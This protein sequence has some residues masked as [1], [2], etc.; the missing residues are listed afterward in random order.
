[1][2]K[3]HKFLT[4]LLIVILCVCMVT[5]LIACDKED[6]TTGEV[7]DTS[8]FIANGNFEVTTSD[9][10]P[11]IPGS[12]TGSAGSTTSGNSTDLDEDSLVAGVID[13]EKSAYDKNKKLWNRLPNPGAVATT[14]SNILMIYNKKDNSY[15]YTSS[16]FSLSA[17]K[18]FQISVSVKTDKLTDNSYGAYIKIAGDAFTEFE[19]IKTGGSWQTYTTMIKTSNLSSNSISVVLSNGKD[20][21]KDGKLSNG[22]AF[23]DNVVVTEVKDDNGGK[24]AEEKYNDFAAAAEN[25]EQQ[26]V[27]D[28]TNG[29]TSFI[30]ISGSEN[31]FTARKW[32]GVSSSGDDGETAPTGSDYLERGVIDTST[33]GI[34]TVAEGIS[35]KG[36]DSKFL[37]LNNK[38]ATAYGYRS[39][40]RFKIVAN[41][42]YKLSVWVLTKDI[43]SNG[44]YLML[45]TSTDKNEQVKTIDNITTNGEWSQ[46]SFYIKGDQKRNKEI[47]LQVGLGKGGKNDSINNV[48]GIAF[49]DEITLETIEETD[50]NN[51]SADNKA[52]LESKLG[53]G[54]NIINDSDIYAGDN[55]KQ[56]T[57][58]KNDG[59]LDANRG[60][61]TINN[62]VIKIE[63]TNPSITKYNYKQTL[64]IAANNHYRLSF[65]VKTEN[66]DS[67]RGIEIIIYK[68][69]NE[70]KDTELTKISDFNS[71]DIEEDLLDS[72]GYIE[73][74]FLIQGD[75]KKLS[76]IYFEVVMGTGSNLTPNS[77]VKGAV[78]LTE[79]EMYKVNYSDYNSESSS[80][81]VKKHS[82]KSESL[83]ITNAE[84][85][86]IDISATKTQYEDEFD[87]E[88]FLNGNTEKT[89]FGLPS[90]WTTSS[91]DMLK[92]IYAGVYD[93][94]NSV[95]KQ[96]LALDRD[97]IA[98]WGDEPVAKDNTNLLVISSNKKTGQQIDAPWGFTS[99]SVSLSKGKYYEL[100]VWAYLY[101]GAD[102]TINLQ[103][104]NKTN[105]E[106]FEI[107]ATDTGWHEYTFYINAGFDN[108][109]IY[110]ELKLGGNAEVKTDGTVFFDR[111]TFT[112]IDSDR[113]DFYV[114]E[115]IETS[116]KYKKAVT[117]STTTFDNSTSNSDNEALDT[118]DGWTGSHADTDAPNGKGKS[119]AGVYNRDHGSREWFGGEYEDG[120]EKAAISSEDL[121]NIMDTAPQL[122]IATYE[123]TIEGAS[124]NNVL[125]INNNAASEYTYTTTLADNSLTANKY[126][127]IS[128]FVLTYDVD[129]S[130]TAKIA[131]K[132]HNSTFE[133]SNN[134]S[135]GINVNTAGKWRRYSFFISTE[136]NAD[137]DSVQLS[138]SLGASGEE[139]YVSGYLFIDNVSISEITED[140]FN[141]QV[142]ADK[143]PET[144]EAESGF[145]FDKAFSSQKH[146]IVFTADDLNKEPEEEKEKEV[147]PLLWLYITSG[148]IGGLIVIVVIIFL[149]KKF[150]VFAR[151]SKKDNFNEKGS[152][153]YNRNRVEANKANAQKRDINQKHQD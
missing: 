89:V 17:N 53:T 128:V 110:L 96:L 108:S 61:L 87:E 152:E 18:I 33:S 24:T 126:Y 70:G 98:E 11:K 28:L 132:L 124:N 119:I 113:Y 59:I 77:L 136:D 121:I 43:E 20:G 32:T 140:R 57:Y 13:T 23:F 111:P 38:Q 73:L 56:G 93:V 142:P 68:K 26:A 37:M 7:K 149:L 145:E 48:K 40:N 91:K 127:E 116:P 9:T 134:E 21:K 31:P 84:F 66:I 86:Q 36:K 146:R 55:Y 120:K 6:E 141:E 105:I 78:Y 135:R 104:S 153:T 71:K 112:E 44:A 82:L 102:A 99:P 150:N 64:E 144:N 42:Y 92:D 100:S 22:Y 115:I 131:L 118:P 63:N 85:N 151:F 58:D 90:N 81:Y 10:F 27:N 1:M 41:K 46:I 133:F 65:K 69:N 8:E 3:K 75:L 125:V 51:A 74:A 45:K 34:P 101:K 97:L 50:Y 148:I 94:T 122:N 79:F 49:F 143:F 117:F 130:K 60:K 129:S 30:N 29:D 88:K 139:N 76:E 16:N 14:D 123:E 52:D 25:N 109:T 19:S 103:S 39:D 83:S 2:N 62:K 80:D 35:P 114:K 5:T 137:I 54:E 107:K 12:W 147:D 67:D 15:K 72:D 95:Q 4:I 138:V 106:S 47:Y